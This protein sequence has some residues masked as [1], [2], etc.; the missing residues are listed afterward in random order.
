M[1]MKR[2]VLCA[3]AM[4][5]VSIASHAQYD[6]YDDGL[7]LYYDEDEPEDT[8]PPHKAY[9]NMVYVQY[10]PTRYHFDGATPHLHFQEFSLGYA[11]SI[12]VQEKTPLFVEGGV[13]MKYSYSEGDPAHQDASFRLFTFRVPFNVV[14]KFYFSQREIALVPYAGVNLRMSAMAKQKLDGK[15]TDLFDDNKKN[16]TGV[17]WEWAQLGWQVGLR[18]YLNHIYTGVSYGRDFPDDSKL[19]EMRECSVHVGYCF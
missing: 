5:C 10:S 19:P 17:E 15:T 12:E 6:N 3:A 11:R 8:V 13:Q 1:K 16:A 2:L 18:F 9:K 14:Y 7:G 4:W